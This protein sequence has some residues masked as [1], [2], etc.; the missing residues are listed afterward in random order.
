MYYNASK[1]GEVLG[2]ILS[3]LFLVLKLNSSSN[4]VPV[5]IRLDD[6]NAKNIHTNHCTLDLRHLRRSL[7]R[8]IPR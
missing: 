1:D 3:H 6:Q 8:A 4:P 5:H 7:A 2:G